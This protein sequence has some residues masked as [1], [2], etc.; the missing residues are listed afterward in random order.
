M[1]TKSFNILGIKWEN[2]M[3]KVLFAALLVR[4]IAVIFSAGY[5]MHDDHFL[6]IEASASWADGYDYNYWLPWTEGNRGK[7]EGHSFTYV[8]LNFLYFYGMKGLGISNPKVLM[9]FN[10]LIHALAS[11]LVVWYGMKITE[12]MSNRQQAITVGWILGML[13]ILVFVS[14]RNLVEV[15][16]LPFLVTGCW[17]LLKDQRISSIFIGGILIGMAVSFRY[18]IGVFAIGLA[19]YFLFSKAFKPFFVFSGGV[20]LTFIITQGIVDYFIWGY[21]FA[22]AISY[23]TYN[24]NEGTT[25]LPNS[26]YFMYVIVLCGCL[27]VP[28][29]LLTGWGFVASAKKHAVLFV[30]TLLFLVFHTF[31]PNRQERFILSILPFFVM[32]GIMGYHTLTQTD[33]IKQWWKVSYYIF[34]GLNAFFLVFASTMYSKKSRVEAMYALYGK[35][36]GNEHILLEGSSAGRTSMMPKFYSGGWNMRFAER[37]DEKSPLQ[38][39]GTPAY[40]YIFFFDEKKLPERL[41]AYQTLYP[42]MHLVKKAEPSLVDWMLRELNPRN[43]N[44]YIEVWKTK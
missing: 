29:G 11:L 6:I 4:L 21:P 25:Y 42:K 22:E 39:E 31:Y 35:V 20:L 36:K 1:S 5:G 7:P 44:E 40:D 30:P 26:N 2:P 15:A 24:M 9:L 3:V 38:P 13:W 10:R 19:L 14:V 34:W 41:T 18:Q 32:L 33:R 37:T 27:F 43:A 17:S 23:I 12:K 28:F 16:A 8:G